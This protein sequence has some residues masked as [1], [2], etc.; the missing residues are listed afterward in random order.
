MYTEKLAAKYGLEIDTEHFEGLV[1]IYQSGR[2][3]GTPGYCKIFTQKEIDS[4]P[5]IE[6]EFA[7][8]AVEALWSD[9]N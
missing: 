5:D 9:N 2:P 3:N 8:I 4:H 6:S 1:F 7:A